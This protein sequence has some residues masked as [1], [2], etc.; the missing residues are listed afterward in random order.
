MPSEPV[1]VYTGPARTGEALIAANA[2]DA[3]AQTVH[4]GKKTRAASK[5]PVAAGA[6]SE[7]V[8]AGKE[9]KPARA[10]GPKHAHVRPDA[11]AAKPA[12]RPGAAAT[13]PPPARTAKPAPSA[14]PVKPAP[15]STEATPLAG[16]R[17]AAAPRN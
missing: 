5:K 1:I 15:K 6:K 17:A 14:K 10:A 8:V 3:A 9:A 4:R 16:Q 2:A 13:K 7:A 11:G 12:E